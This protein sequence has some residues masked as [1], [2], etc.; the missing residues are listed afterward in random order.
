M[1][2]AA[3]ITISDSTVAGTRV[4]KSGP[5]TVEKLQAAGFQVGLSVLPDDRE[6][7]AERLRQLA[8]SGLVSAVFTSGGTGISAR[9]VTPEATRDVIDFEIPGMAEEMRRVSQSK[10]RTAMLSRAVVGVRGKTL[11]VNLPGSPKGAVEN[12]EAILDVVPHA[13]DLLEG[14]TAH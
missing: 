12:L 3:V 10:I 9:D 2:N 13:I 11:I 14:R 8:D 7:I 4:D 1:K 6:Q 5:A